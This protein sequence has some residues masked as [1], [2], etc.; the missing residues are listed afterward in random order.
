MFT[1]SIRP[2]GNR[3]ELRRR[4]SRE[5]WIGANSSELYD[6]T[7]HL[8]NSFWVNHQSKKSPEGKKSGLD[9][10]SG[11]VY[12]LCVLIISFDLMN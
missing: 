8:F 1:F 3:V 4:A 10:L 6:D 7:D 9:N 5:E 12:F 11:A 2:I